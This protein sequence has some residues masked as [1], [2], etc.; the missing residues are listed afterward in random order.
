MT[1]SNNQRKQSAT[2]LNGEHQQRHT[3]CT[4]QYMHMLRHRRLVWDLILVILDHV[5]G[6]TP[7]R[8]K[9][10][11]RCEQCFLEAHINNNTRKICQL[12]RSCTDLLLRKQFWITLMMKEAASFSLKPGLNRC[13]NVGKEAMS[14]NRKSRSNCSYCCSHWH[15][16]ADTSALT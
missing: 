1:T 9:K 8:Q 4:S 13:L 3:P 2:I 12:F 5:V 16:R 11:E 7:V 15:T 10:R 6:S 14:N